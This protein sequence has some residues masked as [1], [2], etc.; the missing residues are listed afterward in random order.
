MRAL[1]IHQ[2][3]RQGLENTRNKVEIITEFLL[4]YDNYPGGFD[5]EGSHFDESNVIAHF[6]TKDRATSDGKYFI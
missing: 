2:K 5:F 6:R 3:K 4:T 1:L